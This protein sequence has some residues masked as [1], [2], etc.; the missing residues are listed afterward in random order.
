MHCRIRA[1]LAQGHQIVVARL[2]RLAEPAPR[3]KIAGDAPQFALIGTASCVMVFAAR[4]RL[5]L[6]MMMMVMVLQMM[7][8]MMMMLM[9]IIRLHRRRIG[10]YGALDLIEFARQRVGRILNAAQA[11]LD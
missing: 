10:R 9:S 6:M 11:A 8:M 1:I 4:Q 3:V 5:L 2:A 7:V